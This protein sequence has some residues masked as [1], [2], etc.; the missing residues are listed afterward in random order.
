[1]WLDP[2]KIKELCAAQGLSLRAI[3]R[4]AGVSRTAYYSL[5]AAPSLLPSS[6]HKLARALNINASQLVSSGS[7]AEELYRSRLSA[8][9]RIMRGNP[10][11]NRENIWHTL[12]LLE[13]RPAERLKGALRRA[14]TQI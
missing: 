11:S 2:A 4:R 7:P 3:L 8:L 14:S 9:E 5:V 12:V 13:L 10:R 1:M 6:A